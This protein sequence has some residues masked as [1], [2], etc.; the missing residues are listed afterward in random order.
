MQGLKQARLQTNLL[1]DEI[2]VERLVRAKKPWAVAAAA[3]LLLASGGLALSYALEYR[4]Y[5]DSERQGCRSKKADRRQQEGR[6]T[7]IESIRDRQE[8]TP[9]MKR[10]A[11]RT[12]VAGQFERDNWPELYKFIYTAIP[13]PG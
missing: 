9:K 4:T 12:I 5:G 11:V 13:R 8:A 10:H 6:Q 1:P 3:A 7:P 2:R